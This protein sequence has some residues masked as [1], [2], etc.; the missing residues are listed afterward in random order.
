MAAKD[1]THLYARDHDARLIPG[2]SQATPQRRAL[3][4]LMRDPQPREAEVPAVVSPD[5]FEEVFQHVHR[6]DVPATGRKHNR[7]RSRNRRQ[8][9]G[10]RPTAGILL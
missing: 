3:Q 10:G 9:S 2:H 8:R 1:F 7:S 5:V 4:V 6:D